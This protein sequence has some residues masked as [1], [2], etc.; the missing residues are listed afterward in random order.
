MTTGRLCLLIATITTCICSYSAV[1]QT[2]SGISVTNLSDPNETL[3]GNYRT[4]EFRT[5]NA[6]TSDVTVNGLTRSFT[7][8]FSWMMGQRVVQPEAQNFA[9][10]Y[11]RKIGY[12]IQFTVEDEH[13]LGYT[14]S[15]SHF[16]RGYATISRDES[17]R[18]RADSLPFV[19]RFNDGEGPV[20]YSGL[21]VHGGALAIYP[22]DEGNFGNKLITSENEHTSP[23]YFGTKTFSISFSSLP[24]PGASTVFQNYGSGE[25]NLRFGFDPS[26]TSSEDPSQPSLE[27]ASYPGADG[28]SSDNLG[29]SVTI[30]VTSSATFVDTDEDGISDDVDNCINTPNQDQSDKDG[31]GIGDA[32]DFVLALL[33]VIPQKINC[34]GKGGVV[35][36]VVYG[37]KSVDLASTELSKI[38]VEGTPVSDR[39]NRH[40]L[41]DS[42]N[43]GF[44]DLKLHLERV[45]LCE[46][47]EGK[48]LN[49]EFDLTL[50]IPTVGGD[51]IKATGR[52]IIHKR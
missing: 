3:S 12:E 50:E 47:L 14:I 17:Y 43:D 46:A 10:I 37:S 23:E 25:S 35:P 11:Q 49:K 44:Q 52:T 21:N 30:V 19:G 38:T 16:I 51:T 13:Q 31:D 45:E 15:I 2:V 20:S 42:N 39:H 33:E 28:E 18:V 1:A 48:P 36:A 6:S 5:G 7:N 24:S 8:R 32:C 26:H 41:S 34:K 9:L 22:A 4:R 40:Q 29:H 27:H